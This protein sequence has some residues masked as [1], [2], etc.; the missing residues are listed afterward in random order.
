MQY[1]NL[2]NISVLC[3]STDLKGLPWGKWFNQYK[4]CNYD[5]Q[6]LEKKIVNLLDDDEVQN[7]KGIY[8]YLLNGNE[9]VLNLREFDDNLKR[10]KYEEQQGICPQ[11]HKHFDFEEME[12]DHIIPW[13]QGGKTDYNNL[14][15]LCKHCNRVKSNN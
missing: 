1:S 4:D 12:G 7:Q 5:S 15:M 14:Q 11:C 3:L 6:K 10:R 8:E 13:S 2:K 9:N